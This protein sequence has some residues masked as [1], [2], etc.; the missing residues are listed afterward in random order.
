MFSCL[1][2]HLRTAAVMVLRDADAAQL[3]SSSWHHLCDA[4]FIWMQKTRIRESGMLLPKCQ[5][6]G[7]PGKCGRARV[8]QRVML[9]GWNLVWNEDSG[10]S[11]MPGPWKAYPTEESHRQWVGLAEKRGHV[12]EKKKSSKAMGQD[13]A[14]LARPHASDGGGCRVTELNVFL[15]GLGSSLF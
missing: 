13:P 9:W 15:L 14:R 4:V 7:K 10:I 8:P 6:P 12:A 2:A 1:V 5:G 3:G 11:E